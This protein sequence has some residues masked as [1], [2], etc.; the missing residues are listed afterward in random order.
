[1]AEALYKILPAA[2]WDAAA[3]RLPTSPIDRR[4]GFLHL[5]TGAQVR[6]TARRHFAGQADLVLLTLDASRFVPDTL[7]WEPSRGGALFPH[8]YGDVPRAAVVRV[9]PLVETDGDFRFPDWV[10][11]G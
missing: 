8:V 5:S 1:M 9:D 7:R 4:D 10:D 6:E 2:A 3:D 11:A